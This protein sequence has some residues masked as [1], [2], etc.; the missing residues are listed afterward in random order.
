MTDKNENIRYTINLFEII[1]TLIA[2]APWIALVSIVS[3]FIAYFAYPYLTNK[4]YTSSFTIHL[5]DDLETTTRFNLLNKINFKEGKDTFY[6]FD[7]ENQINR[8]MLL[9][10]YIRFFRDQDEISK[11]LKRNISLSNNLSDQEIELILIS[12]FQSIFITPKGDFFEFQF[13]YNDEEIITNITEDIRN[14]SLRY[15]RDNIFNQLIKKRNQID[16]LLNNKISQKQNKLKNIKKDYFEQIKRKILFLSEQK[17]L[18][19]T[20][21]IIEDQIGAKDMMFLDGDST[22]FDI[23]FYYLRGSK[24][25]QKEIEILNS[26]ND[27][28]IISYIPEYLGELRSLELFKKKLILNE[29]DSEIEK[30]FQDMEYN[31]FV[32][33]GVLTISN[34]SK[35]NIATSIIFIFVFLLSC[36]I[37]LYQKYKIVNIK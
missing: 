9:E 20:L 3:T 15:S 1:E 8:E 5:A 26:R 18:A 23:D 16:D 34:N 32:D 13:N 22:E 17:E 19:L 14:S 6:F 31:D 35:R 30:I 33:L 27:N 37:I 12:N 29:I 7:Q 36:L 25:I 28:E 4:S 21:G 10:N 11:I 24:A 2:K